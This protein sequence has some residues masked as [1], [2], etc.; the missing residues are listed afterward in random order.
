MWL[1]WTSAALV[2]LLLLG[3]GLFF[4]LHLGTNEAVPLARAR[5][6]WRWAQALGLI[7]FNAWIWG[8]VIHGLWLIW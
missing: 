6:L 8:R 3:A 4:A 1:L 2:G 7:T 5:L